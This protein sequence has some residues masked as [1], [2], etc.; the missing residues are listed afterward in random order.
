[1]PGTQTINEDTTTAITGISV[2]DADAASDNLSTQLT[3]T[4]GILNVTLA[5]GASISAGANGS[6]SLTILGT[7]ADVNATLASLTY[8]GNNNVNGTAADTLT[9]ATSDLGN[10]GAGGAQSDSDAVQIDLVAVNDTPVVTAPGSVLTATEQIGLNI[11]G[12]GYSITDVDAAAGILTAT[13]TWTEGDLVITAGNSGVSIGASTATSQIFTGTLAQLNNLLTGTSTGSIVYTNNSDTPSTATT[14]TLLVN[15]GGNTG[16]DPLLTADGTSEEH[17]AVQTINITAVND[18]PSVA[19]NLGVTVN[20]GSTG[21]VIN[22]TRL[23]EGDPDDSGAG[24]TYTVSSVTNNGTLRNNGTALGLND[25]FSQA[26]IDANLITYD[27]NGS[28]TT[29]DSFN[30]SLADGGENSATPATGTFTITV[31][32]QND[33]PVQTVPGTQ[34]INEDTTTRP[35]RVFQ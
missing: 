17:S 31:N 22:N 25:T 9:V 34:T 21:N 26:D 11:H 1:M 15:D 28:E 6:A 8:R 24:L 20:E 27:H 16:T 14:L 4:A 23:N 30:F 32:A 5:G 10:N 7:Q 18:A 2:S 13:F 33:A 35:S 12:A 3:V 29:S 19:T